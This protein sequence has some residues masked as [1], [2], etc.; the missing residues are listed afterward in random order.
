MSKN[1]KFTLGV[2]VG[3]IIGVVAGWFTA[4]KTGKE[5]R[6]DAKNKTKE[7]YEDVRD[8]SE[9][10]IDDAKIKLD[11]VSENAKDGFGWFKKDTEK[12]AEKDTKVVKKAIKEV[13]NK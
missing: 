2:A 9:D 1:G 8:K 10:L 7:V 13:K 5:M 6:A 4:P 3:T 11:E 12:D